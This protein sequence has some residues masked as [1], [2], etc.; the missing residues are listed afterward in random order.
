M[1]NV[2]GT[3]LVFGRGKASGGSAGGSAGRGGIS[4]QGEGNWRIRLV[5]GA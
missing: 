4:G 3:Q 5:S 2:G 1:A